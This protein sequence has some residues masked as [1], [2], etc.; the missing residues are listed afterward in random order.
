[1]AGG[2]SEKSSSNKLCKY[3]QKS[4]VTTIAKCVKCGECY[5]TSCALRV[6]GLIAVGKNNLVECCQRPAGEVTSKSVGECTS[7]TINKLLE[8][9]DEVIRSRDEVINEL[10]AKEVLL[11]KNI[12]LLEEKCGSITHNQ[13]SNYSNVAD[14]AVNLETASYATRL[15]TNSNSA[16]KSM[17]TSKSWTSTSTLLAS[18]SSMS[19]TSNPNQN[20]NTT[21]VNQEKQ[22]FT[23]KTVNAAVTEALISSKMQEIQHLESQQAVN[24]TQNATNFN[25]DWHEVRRRQ[26]RFVV[27]RNEENTQIQTIPKF[28]HLHVTRLAPGT[29]PEQLQAF[30]KPNFPDVQC[31]I[32]LS[33]HPEIYTSMKVKIRQDDFKKAWKREVWPSEAIVS[34]F[35]MKKRMQPSMEDPQN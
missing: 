17:S 5:H 7:E 19:N 34:R 27:G 32:H 21:V 4:V 3:C 28:T 24:K 1:M 29:K 12:K 26:R 25:S 20:K 13:K 16:P 6:A 8:V 14:S 22:R 33:K 23:V 35:F 11:Y 30:L 2:E 15:A 18:T 9:K 10:R 31:E